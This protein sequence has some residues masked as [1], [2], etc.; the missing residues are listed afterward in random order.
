MNRL[1]IHDILFRVEKPA[2][3]LGNELNSYHKN[4]DTETIRFGFCF[5]DIYEIGMSHLGMQILYHLL[6]KEDNIFCERVFSPAIDME[7]EMR[8]NKIPL[9]G[10]ESR[11]P[12]KH[13][14]FLGF[15]LQYE[16]S[17]TNILNML[18][19]AGIPLFASERGEEDPLIMV[20]GP[21]AYNPEPLAD[22]VDIVIL[23]E[24]EE[25]TLEVIKDYENMKKKDDFKRSDFLLKIAPIQGVYIPSLYNVEYHQEGPIKA[26]SPVNNSVPEKI[27]K[28][29]IEN[30]D[31]VFYPEEIIVPY[32]NTVHDRI[33]LEVFRG[34]TR[35]CRFC[36]AGMIYR[37]VREKGFDRLK[38]L[39]EKLLANT[40]YEEI[41]LAS[42][43]TSDYSKLDKLVRHLI[44]EYEKDKVGIS[45][46]SL[47][48]D[49][50][51]F[52]L[53]QEIQKIRKTGLTFAPEA[54][55][56]RLRD[57]IN[58]GLTEDDLTN[59][60][61]KA[62]SLGW[63][64]VKLYFMIGLP[65]ESFEDLDGI[66][67]L[68]L[69]VVD[70]YYHTEKEKRGKGLNVTV[71]ASTFVPKPFT[72]FQWEPLDTLE[73]IYEK[74]KFLVDGLRSK[75]ITFNYH[76][77]KTSFL[78][79]VFARGDRRLSKVLARGL[80]VG[81]K[82][83]GWMEHFD[84]DRWMKVFDECEIDPAFYANRRRSYDEIL[85]WDHIDVGVSKDFLVRENEKAKSGELTVDCRTNCSG[86]GINQGFI[87]GIC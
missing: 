43:S 44:D 80:E 79:A 39:T 25:V 66:R 14:D 51:T 68:A 71:S 86:C 62:F 63:S 40:G 29:I 52:E 7:E 84:F 42:L 8:K 49:N 18:N 83:D 59:A 21:C 46:P 41:S 24:A 19:L 55:S 45:L 27:T 35:G 15:T 61:E 75:K 56:Q 85:P 5:P 53:I 87:G 9:F 76:D 33:M 78:E 28:R 1:D 3:Y 74:Q 70:S 11:Q 20:G 65:T 37:P 81:C 26:V 38:D 31:E 57:V 48:L 17:Y 2:R 64:S 22:F 16:L 32:I 54:G 30:L 77:A 23:G 6:N 60:V 4:I 69:K 72:P 73:A 10:L 12:I 13:F 36:Q 82:F 67:D 34:C 50:F 58:K 47:R